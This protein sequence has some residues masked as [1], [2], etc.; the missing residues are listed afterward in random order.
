MEWDWVGARALL[1]LLPKAEWK[2]TG[3][4]LPHLLRTLAN[5]AGYMAGFFWFL[6]FFFFSQIQTD[7]K[8]ICLSS[9][10]SASQILYSAHWQP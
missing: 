2:R 8:Q 4:Q 5:P 6:L 9:S 10:C 7:K 3:C 1:Q